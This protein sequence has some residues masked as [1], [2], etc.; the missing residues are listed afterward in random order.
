[1]DIAKLKAELAAG[2][3]DTGAYNADDE[4]ATAQLNEPNRKR[5]RSSLSGNEMF[6]ATDPANFAALTDLK[7][8]LWVSWCNTDRDPY[9]AANMAFVQ[10]IFGTGS[11]TVTNLAAIRDENVSRG[12]ELGIGIVYPTHVAHARVYHA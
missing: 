5:P 11:Q 2:H 12:V 1:M 3:P 7:R 4:V 9:N 10:F 6:T 8:T